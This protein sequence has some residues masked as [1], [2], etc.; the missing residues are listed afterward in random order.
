MKKIIL[1][2]LL[3]PQII[4]AQNLLSNGSF[5]N[6]IN[7]WS[8]VQGGSVELAW[9]SDDGNS[10]NGS[11]QLSDNFN[12]GGIGNIPSEKIPVI[13]QTNYK[14]KGFTKPLADSEALS[15]AV[16]IAWFNDDYQISS[17]SFV[18]VS[19]DTANGNWTAFEG[20]FESPE[21]AKFAEVRIGVEGPNSDSTEYAISLFDDLRFELVTGNPNAFAM[22][23]GHSALWYNRDESGHGINLYMLANQVVIVIWYVYDGQGNPLWL[24]GVGSHDGVKA[25]LT[26]KIY[27]GAMFPPDFDADDVT[28]V[29]WGQFEL[30]FSSCDAGL[31]KWDPVAG[32][33]FTAG[34]LNVV[35]LNTTLGLTCTE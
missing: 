33:G 16:F 22:V 2:A 19:T 26:A 23:P 12:N 24:L 34:E 35:R 20:I 8:E 6:N 7:G 13:E 17:S 10:A 15:S 9:I 32:N 4:L 28:G 3:I 21:G 29:V 5:D 1:I 25:T 30:E 18:H 11:I 14:I 31:F 27:S